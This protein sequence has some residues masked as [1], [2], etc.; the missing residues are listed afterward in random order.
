[1]LNRVNAVEKARE[2]IGEVAVSD[3]EQTASNSEVSEAEPR[4]RRGAHASGDTEAMEE[5]LDTGLYDS[6][7]ASDPVSIT[8][9]TVSGRR[10]PPAPDRH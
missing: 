3:G 1:M 10:K 7:P 4:Q 2:L 5:Q 6:F 9:T 8:I